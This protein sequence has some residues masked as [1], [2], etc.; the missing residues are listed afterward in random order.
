M[1]AMCNSVGLD[2][3]GA[4]PPVLVLAGLSTLGG[5]LTFGNAG[6]NP[7]VGAY[8]GAQF[9]LSIMLAVGNGTLPYTLACAALGAGATDFAEWFTDRWITHDLKP[10]DPASVNNFE[11]KMWCDTVEGAASGAM[12]GALTPYIPSSLG[13]LFAAV[14]TFLQDAGASISDLT[15][16][17]NLSSFDVIDDIAY[18]FVDAAVSGLFAKFTGDWIDGKTWRAVTKYGRGIGTKKLAKSVA[19]EW[20]AVVGTLFGYVSGNVANAPNEKIKQEFG[21]GDSQ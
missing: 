19:K 3:M 21:G 7:L 10:G 20:S 8:F 16:S 17:T 12:V 18:P 6:Q 14:T 5:A 15:T 9:G 11:N 13:S 4:G 2:A 1:V